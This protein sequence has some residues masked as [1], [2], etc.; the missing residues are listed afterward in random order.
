MTIPAFLFGVL[1]SSLLGAIFHLWKGGSLIR[2]LLY[3]VLAWIGFWGGHILAVQLDWHFLS[4]GPLRLGMA[5]VGCGI[6]LVIGHWLSQ[7]KVQGHK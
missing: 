6:I 4:L 2:V 1:L 5:L 7:V 3:L